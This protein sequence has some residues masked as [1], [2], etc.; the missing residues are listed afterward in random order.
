MSKRNTNIKDVAEKAHNVVDKA[1]SAAEKA[2]LK[3]SQAS[4]QVK[5]RAEE[6]IDSVKEASGNAQD[7]VVSYVNENPLKSIGI[8]FGAGIVAA[9]LLRK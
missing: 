3:A 2:E 1:A 5:E 4:N 8:A 9:A 6:A 7:K